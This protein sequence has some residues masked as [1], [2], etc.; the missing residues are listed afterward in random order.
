VAVNKKGVDVTHYFIGEKQFCTILQSFNQEVITED[1]IQACCSTHILAVSK[2]NLLELYRQLPFMADLINQVHQQ[3]ILEKIRLKNAYNG[4]DALERYK[5][6]LA[7]QS[8]IASRVPLNYIA[9]YLNVTPQS[10][11]RIRRKHF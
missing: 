5:V 2:K 10:L 4:Q 9:S 6:F 8:D 1:G 7:E 3:R 11:S